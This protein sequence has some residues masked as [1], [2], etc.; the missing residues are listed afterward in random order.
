MV[1]KPIC[2]H[3]VAGVQLFKRC[4]NQSAGTVFQGCSCLS[5]VATYLLG[6]VLPGCNCLSGVATYLPAQCCRDAAVIIVSKPTY[7]HCAAGMQLFKWCRNLSAGTVLQRF[8][9]FS[10]V[11]TFLPTLC[12][13]GAAVSAVSQHICRALC[14][15]GAA[16]LQPICGY[17]AAWVRLFKCCRNLSAGTVLQGCSCLSGVK[18]YLPGLCSRGAA[19]LAVSK[20]FCWHCVAEV[21]LF[22]WCQNL[23]ASTVLQRCS[24]LSGVATYLPVLCCSEAAV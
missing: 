21:Q 16:V 17:C 20:P 18:T 4:P 13:R 19:V 14:C 5:S 22:K 23:S 15:R 2:L 7:Q 10:S 3:C 12:C 1:L 6:T 9:C 11:K 8:S 24:Y